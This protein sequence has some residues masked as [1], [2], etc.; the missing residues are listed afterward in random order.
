M[1]SKAHRWVDLQVVRRVSRGRQQA[2]RGRGLKVTAL[3]E[4][5]AEALVEWRDAEGPVSEVVAVVQAMIEYEL[6]R[7]QGEKK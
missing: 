7:R 1:Q 6:D 2:V 5:L 3:M 4:E